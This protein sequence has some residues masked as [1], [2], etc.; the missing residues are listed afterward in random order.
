MSDS[1]KTTGR[2]SLSR[3]ELHLVRQW[4]EATEDCAPRSLETADYRLARHVYQILGW[5]VPQR[6]EEQS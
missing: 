4:F 6:V 3:E 1:A 5:A 2:V